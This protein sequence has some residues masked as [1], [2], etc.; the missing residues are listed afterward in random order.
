MAT[1]RRFQILDPEAVKYGVNSLGG[2][3]VSEHQLTK[4]GDDVEAL[5]K[6]KAI[7]LVTP[8]AKDA[9]E[10]TTDVA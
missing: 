8:E 4:A 2:A 6:A 5:L 9:A 7:R 1:T 3:F 10:K